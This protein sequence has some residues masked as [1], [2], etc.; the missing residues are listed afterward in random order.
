LD[1]KWFRCTI[2]IVNDGRLWVSNLDQPIVP[3]MSGSPI[4][5]DDGA[6]IGVVALAEVGSSHFLAAPNPRL[7][8][9]LS[10]RWKY[11]HRFLQSIAADV[12]VVF[13]DP[14]RVVAD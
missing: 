3:G 8:R 14:L 9:D 1:Q 11:G 4:T 10:Y 2:Q 13:V 12:D 5:S 7:V 6:A